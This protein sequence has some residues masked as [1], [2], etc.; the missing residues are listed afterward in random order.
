MVAILENQK[1]SAFGFGYVSLDEITKEIK[2]LDAKK[3]CQ[4]TVI[5][6][7]VIKNNSDIFADFFFLN[8]NNCIASSVFPSNFKNAEITPVYKKDSKNT[9]SNYRLVSILSNISKIYEKCTFPKS[10]IT[11]KRYCQDINLV[12]KKDTTHYNVCWS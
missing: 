8:L 12:F 9:E 6:T 7:K 11:S 4:D 3:F 1:D 2:R 5:H 10:Q